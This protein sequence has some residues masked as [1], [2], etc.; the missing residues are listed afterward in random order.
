[1]KMELSFLE[2]KVKEGT[3]EQLLLMNGQYAKMWRFQAGQYIN[4]QSPSM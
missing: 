1:M 4:E 3:H 2:E